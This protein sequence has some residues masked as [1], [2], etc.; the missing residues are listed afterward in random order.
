M[1]KMTEIFTRTRHVLTILLLSAALSACATVRNTHGVTTAQ[2]Q[3]LV[4]EGFVDTPDGW[5]LSMQDQLLFDVDSSDIKPD[6][7]SRIQHLSENLLRV[8]IDHARIDGHTDDSGST[9][10]NLALSLSRAQS[11]AMIMAQS[12][13]TDTNLTTA[14]RGEANPIADNS[15]ADGKQR[16]RRVNIII[17]SI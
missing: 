17:S 10:H 6:M 14:G 16:N 4:A 8:G 3:V 7:R 12:G 15:T 2:R 1:T 9:E 11:V 5:L 13:F